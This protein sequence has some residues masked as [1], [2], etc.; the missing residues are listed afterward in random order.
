MRA[1]F[2]LVR[3]YRRCGYTVCQSVC[4]AVRSSLRVNKW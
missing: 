1:F 2:N 4:R 3:Y